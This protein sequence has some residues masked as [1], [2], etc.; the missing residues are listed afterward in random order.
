MDAF[1]ASIEQRDRP[2]LRGRPVIV[3]ASPTGRGVVSAASYEA[4]PYGVR[5]A[6]PISRA[7][8]LCPHAAFVPVDMQKYQRVSAQIM[9]IL[10]DFSPLVEPV[11]VDEAFVDLSGTDSLFGSP[12]DAVRLIKRRILAE[13]GLTASAGL[14]ANKFVAKVAS[15]LEKPDGLVVVVAGDEARFLGALPIERLWGV[16]RVMAKALGD[17]GFTT[18]GQLQRAPRAILGRRFGKHGEA[19]HDLAFGRDDRPVEPYG[20][21]KSIGA[22]ETFG[23]DCTNPAQLKTTLRAHAERV[24]AELREGGFSAGRVTLKLR[25]APFE[26]HTRSVSGEPT[27]DGLELYR[28]ALALLERDRVTRPVRLIGLSASRLG[29]SGKGQLDLLDPAALRR[30]RLAR[31][32]DRLTARFGEGTVI[33]AVLLPERE[34]E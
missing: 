12:L 10:V 22:E 5:S 24:A 18:I 6:M 16:G 19:L 15:E 7:A 3:G 21:P 20:I 11:S 13:T 14:A 8:R 4:R 33:P 2:E 28:R 9:G 31:V 34:G 32:V 1:Y 27:Q 26:T 29:P 17:L 23:V 25:L 30:E